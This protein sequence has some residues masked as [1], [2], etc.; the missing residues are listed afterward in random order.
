GRRQ[1]LRRSSRSAAASGRRRHLEGYPVK[2][3]EPLGDRAPAGGAARLARWCP[4]DASLRARRRPRAM[5]AGWHLPRQ[6]HH[7][8]RLPGEMLRVEDH[9]AAGGTIGVMNEGKDEAFLFRLAVGIGHEERL[10]DG[11]P[12]RELV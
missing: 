8:Q 7:R 2:S 11:L 5:E 10:A 3:A 4:S 6:M 12:R 9:E 1:I